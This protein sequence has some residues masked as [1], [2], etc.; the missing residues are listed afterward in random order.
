M[1]ENAALNVYKSCDYHDLQNIHVVCDC[2][3]FDHTLTASLNSEDKSIDISVS[4]VNTKLSFRD[5]IKCLFTG[6]ATYSSEII[7]TERSAF[8]FCS[9]ILSAIRK[10]NK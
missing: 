3:D 7:L 1:K 4:F 10:M 2:G 5:R 8:T 9:E 6:R